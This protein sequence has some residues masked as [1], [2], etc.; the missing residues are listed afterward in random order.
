MMQ[1]RS[2]LIQKFTGALLGVG[3]G[4]AL[5]APLEGTSKVS[6]QMLMTLMDGQGQLRYTD[7]TH[8]TLGL[9]ESLLECGHFDG[10]HL[11]TIW[12]RNYR[13]EP[14]R[15]YGPGP[16]Q[17]FDL[18]EGGVPWDQAGRQLHGGKG[19]WGN[20]AAMRVAPAALL[21]FDD[22]AA[23]STLARQTALI[24]HTHPLGV[25]GAVLQATAIASLLQ[26]PLGPPIDIPQLLETLRFHVGAA[27][28]CH[29]LDALP[30]FLPGSE[31][32]HEDVTQVLGNG[33]AAHQSVVTAL[34]CF[35]R[36]PDNFEAAITLALR[37]G[38]DTDTIASMTG[39]LTGAYRGASAIPQPWR[40][41][42]EDAD[43]LHNWA[44]ALLR[45][46]R[47]QVAI[48]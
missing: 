34:Y 47:S 28:Y 24:T 27:E 13:E 26:H 40:T 31:W 6:R 32:E 17:V 48:P 19:S 33:V 14:W 25:E 12:A 44:V 35:L 23:V 4:D 9:A 22:L 7:D 2:I 15:G 38:G 30:S 42:L 5:G 18:L 41:R 8:M 45:L 36:H 21:H 20:G 11:A 39:A 10:A 43:M 16:G 3:V 1:P 46:A 37:Q 29:Q